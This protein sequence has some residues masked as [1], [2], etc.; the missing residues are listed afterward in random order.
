MSQ[1]EEEL[2]EVKQN[3]R[4]VTRQINEL[5]DQKKDCTAAVD[6]TEDDLE[7]WENSA[8]DLDDG[9]TVY[10]PK[11]KSKKRKR[12]FNATAA[13]RKK[14]RSS[15]D[16]DDD[17]TDYIDSASEDDAS[18]EEPDSNEGDRNP[19]TREQVDNKLEELRQLKKEA[20]RQGRDLEDRIRE[21]RKQLSPLK[22]QEDAIDAKQNTLCI[23]GRNE[24]SRSA[25]QQDFASGIRELDQENAEEENPESFNPDEDIRDYDQV[26][27]DLPIFCVS[28]R[29]YQ[30]LSGRLKKDNDVAGFETSEQTEIPQLQAH[31]KKLTENGRQASCRRFLNSLTQLLTSLGLFASDDGTG[32]KMT[33]QQRD[34]ERSFL[35]RELK[36]LEKALEKAVSTTMEDVEATL[37]EQIFDKFAPAVRSAADSA[38]P[39]SA[40]WGAHKNDGGLYWATYKAT[41][42][43][44]GVY[45]GAAGLRDFNSELSEPI[46]KQLASTWEKAFQRR[47]PHI[48]QSF[49]KSGTGLLK[50]FHLAIADRC[51]KRG[52]G[53]ARI[54]ML[55]NQLQADQGIFGDLAT[56]MIGHVNEGQRDINREF[57]PVIGQV[58]EPAYEHCTNEK[59]TGSFK[60]MKSHMA[61]HVSQNRVSMFENA[62]KQVCKSIMTMC[63][64]VRKD[65]LDRAD[66]I[67]VNMQRDYMSIIGGVNVD[68]KMPRHERALRRDVDEAVGWADGYF[69]EVVDMEE[70]ELKSFERKE[71]GREVDEMEVDDTGH[72]V[73]SES[74]EE[75]AGSGEEDGS[76]EDEEEQA[77]DKERD[78]TP[79]GEGERAST[80]PATY[81]EEL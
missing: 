31:C 39:T 56:A 25:I 22:D 68:T 57:T 66:S 53:V 5:T 78:G 15:L 63:D 62:T 36:R 72:A 79:Q 43:R 75:E 65:M 58:M 47:L 59:G 64:K 74:E 46:Y 3:R 67:W 35:T 44:N 21:L 61:E 73:E 49:T 33:G 6:Q 13:S 8:E 55:E 23:A 50:H 30:K 4:T 54:G 12:G 18:E 80:G 14:R 40:G 41:V 20:R 19:L 60:R 48:L 16:S 77:A 11:P 71:G 1:L 9:Q 24:Y 26:A 70:D 7:A 76:K 42:R 28:S 38:I 45:Q 69:Q 37:G 34:A 10:A 17:D 29:A 27:R 51:R 2:D 32:A 81:E 52:H